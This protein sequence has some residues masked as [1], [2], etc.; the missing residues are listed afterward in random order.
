MNN[1]KAIACL[2][3][4]TSLILLFVP[5]S[6]CAQSGEDF[7]CCDVQSTV[8]V[9]HTSTLSVFSDLPM[10]AQTPQPVAEPFY[11]S[12]FSV[13]AADEVLGILT[14]DRSGRRISKE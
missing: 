13:P 11:A 8:T 1:L 3:G 12:V 9:L 14:E 2:I 5:G 6:L 10:I 7:P 4:L